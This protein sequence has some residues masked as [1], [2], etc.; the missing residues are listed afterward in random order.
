[1]GRLNLKID[2]K[3]VLKNAWHVFLVVVGTLILAFGSGCFL[4]PFNI[5]SGGVTG[6]S[7]L[8]KDFIPVDISAAILT[9]ALFFL[10]LL[11][12]GFKFSVT[13]LISTILYPV[14][15]SLVLR[16]G[17]AEDIAGLI[18]HGEI[19]QWALTN[20]GIDWLSADGVIIDTLLSTVN[21]GKI[22]ICGLLGG[23]C[24][25]VGCSLTFI[26]GGST[27]GLDI[28][29]FIINKFT[30]IKQSVL[31]FATDSI[32]VGVGLIVDLVKQDS[33][34]FVAGLI[35]IIAAFICSFMVE[36]VYVSKEGAFNVDVI[37]D[38]PE[39]IIEYARNEV[40]RSATVFKVQGAYSKEE[41]TMVRITFNRREY[42]KI[43]DGIAKIDPHSF[44]T[45]SQ[46]MLVGGLG[47]TKIKSS[48]S[49][50]IKDAKKAINDK[51]K[52]TTDSEKVEENIK[53]DND[54]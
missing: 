26:G 6:F 23:A 49:N 9:W 45:F 28:L 41:K 53:E 48:D 34:L 22:L 16:L 47:F 40:N 54:R 5:I 20:Q 3:T 32:I 52:N 18:I 10:G 19:Q 38:K 46:T 35:G 12:L 24:V 8:L 50:I 2:K 25:G 29:S 36:V 14:V 43:K 51:K 33:T 37:T 21:T 15:L 7:L 42:M 1:M 30:G 17:L 11:F 44:A 4:V 31:F 27:G 39:E 13:T